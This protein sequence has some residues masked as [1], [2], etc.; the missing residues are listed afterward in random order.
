[1][2]SWQDGLATGTGRR[3][4]WRTLWGADLP[5]ARL[6]LCK[7]SDGGATRPTWLP[8]PSPRAPTAP[9]ATRCPPPSS[10]PP[11][12]AASWLLQA[13]PPLSPP[14]PPQLSSQPSPPAAA[15]CSGWPCCCSAPPP[16]P[17]P[18]ATRRGWS[19][20]R[21]Q[22]TEGRG[23][24]AAGLLPAGRGRFMAGWGWCRR[25]AVTWMAARS[26]QKSRRTAA[27]LSLERL[28]A[29]GV[30]R[31]RMRPSSNPFCPPPPPA[32]PMPP[33]FRCRS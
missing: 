29:S 10:G 16:T 18:N 17:V 26:R 12:G 6:R 15:G 14:K 9:P 11:P 28:R 23:T 33:S 8:T 32:P 22:A 4:R 2:G 5:E 7:G 21:R 13:R 24:L 19:P 31:R 1:M 27:R 3:R 20:M 30:S 25:S